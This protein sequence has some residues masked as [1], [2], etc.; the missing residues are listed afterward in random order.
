[1]QNFSKIFISLFILITISSIGIL[2]SCGKDDAE[3][4]TYVAYD[5]DYLLTNNLNSSKRFTIKYYDPKYANNSVVNQVVSDTF[6][7]RGIQAKSLDVLFI[8]GESIGDTSD[9]RVSIYVDAKEM[10]YD[11]AACDWGCDSLA[12]I[13]YA[14]P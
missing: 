4:M 1:M 10:V 2:S 12:V 11:S 13:N 8:S 5:V 7:V 6:W 9:F 3:E 14:L